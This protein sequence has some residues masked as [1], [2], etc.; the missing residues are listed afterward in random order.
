MFWLNAG[1]AWNMLSSAVAEATFHEPMFALNA[2]A[3]KNAELKVATR[4]VFQLLT[5]W[6]KAEAL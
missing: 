5:S 6:L 4:A 1:A 3:P 2:E